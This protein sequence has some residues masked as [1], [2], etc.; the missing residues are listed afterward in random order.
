MKMSSF[1]KPHL[2]KPCISISFL[3]LLPSNILLS[4]DLLTTLPAASDSA[5]GVFSSDKIPFLPER[6]AQ[7]VIVATRKSCDVLEGDD[8]SAVSSVSD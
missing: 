6:P 4:M 7:P 8:K 5:L 3:R 2:S 1:Y